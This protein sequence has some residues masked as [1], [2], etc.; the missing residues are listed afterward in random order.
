MVHEW[1]KARLWKAAF[2]TPK[3]RGRM[4][5][6]IGS[7]L[8]DMYIVSS[9]NETKGKGYR[10]TK[11]VHN[12]I[13][14]GMKSINRNAEGRRKLGGQYATWS[15]PCVQQLEFSSVLR[16]TIATGLQKI[17]RYQSS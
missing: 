12:E 5:C 17:S 10:T 15:F 6:I 8:D 14:T 16:K 4:D 7:M 13:L 11:N 9:V 3:L 1:A 2:A